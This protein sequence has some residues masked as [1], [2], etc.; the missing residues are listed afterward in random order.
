MMLIN[1]AALHIM[2]VKITATTIIIIQAII[3]WHLAVQLNSIPT[4]LV[5]FSFTIQVYGLSHNNTKIINI[6]V[7][8]T[9]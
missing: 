2:R 6:S 3:I 8:V 5:L 7:I 9:L 4:T 1:N